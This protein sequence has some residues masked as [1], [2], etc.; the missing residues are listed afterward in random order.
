MYYSII[1]KLTGFKSRLCHSKSRKALKASWPK[2]LARA[3]LLRLGRPGSELR[4]MSERSVQPPFPSWPAGSDPV[5]WAGR[6]CSRDPRDHSVD[7]DQH[8]G[9]IYSHKPTRALTRLLARESFLDYT[10]NFKIINCL[11]SLTPSRC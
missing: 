11:E 10:S 6:L 5:V 7:I 2:S 9:R 3:S 4:L 8:I 1:P